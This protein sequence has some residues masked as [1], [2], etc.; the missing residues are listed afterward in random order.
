MGPDRWAEQLNIDGLVVIMFWRV[1][2]EGCAQVVLG[3]AVVSGGFAE[4][5]LNQSLK[6]ICI[7]KWE[8]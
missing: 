2:E 1:Q 7:P 3:W 5:R 6:L 8:A 4:S